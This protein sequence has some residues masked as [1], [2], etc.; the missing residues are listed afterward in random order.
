MNFTETINKIITAVVGHIG[1]GGIDVHPAVDYDNSGFMTPD[2]LK[3]VNGEAIL[4]AD[5]TDVTTIEHGLYMV[6]LQD[7]SK[8]PTNGSAGVYHVLVEN[9]KTGRKQV[10]ALH[11]HTGRLF[12]WTIHT[13]G[14]QGNIPT[15]WRIINQEHSRW[16][17]SLQNVGD[18]ATLTSDFSIAE[19]L[20]ITYS[21]SGGPVQS[22]DV[23]T[24]L[25]INQ[26]K[27]TLSIVNV[28]NSSLGYTISEC[29]IKGGSDNKSIQV[30][31]TKT[32]YNNKGELS[33]ITSESIVI[34]RIVLIM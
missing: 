11:S 8:I 25:L 16:T 21:N 28:A 20:R 15:G 22:I 29:D 3:K 2:L 24:S 14:A 5:N 32:I 6:N 1:R 17:G 34:T 19:Y 18:T 30:S 7:S 13:N 4:L 10:I 12:I 9:D 23:P 26:K 33:E 31:R 27:T